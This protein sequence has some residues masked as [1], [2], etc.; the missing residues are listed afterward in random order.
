MHNDY[1][2]QRRPVS[3]RDGSSSWTFYC[4]R[5]FP[6]HAGCQRMLELFVF[7]FEM[8]TRLRRLKILLMISRLERLQLSF[9]IDLGIRFR[10]SV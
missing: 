2:Q 7:D 4:C 5:P 8:S 1:S 3:T 10:K 9:C 6:V